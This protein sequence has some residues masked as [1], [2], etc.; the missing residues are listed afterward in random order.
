MRKIFTK[1][2]KDKHADIGIGTMIVFIAMVLV[3]AVAAAVL[4]GTANQVR[5][6]ATTTGNEAIGG[7]SSGFIHQSVTGLAADAYTISE[8]YIYLKLNAGSPPIA[9]GNVMVQMIYDEADDLM[10]N[11]SSAVAGTSYKVE[12]VLGIS[13]FASTWSSRY[14]IGQ[15]DMVKVTLAV[16]VANL[17]DVTINIIPAMGQPCLVKFQTPEVFVAGNILD[18]A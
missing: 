12:K 17:K 15:G 16:G 2:K 11:A 4:I 3:A 9:F 13:P 6:Q 7:V 14:I 18:L 10:E 8:I 1:M 5:E